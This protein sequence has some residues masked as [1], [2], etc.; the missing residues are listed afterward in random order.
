LITFPTYR[1]LAANPEM[2][3]MMKITWLRS[4]S[5]IQH[6]S[7]E[8]DRIHYRCHEAKGCQRFAV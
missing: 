4:T 2:R 6:I 8:T 5:V 7:Y 3:Q 1:W